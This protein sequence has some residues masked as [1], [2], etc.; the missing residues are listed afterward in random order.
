MPQQQDADT[1]SLSAV[2]RF[3]EP[4]TPPP[5]EPLA[6]TSQV[7]RS[8]RDEP[9]N[10]FERTPQQLCPPDTHAHSHAGEKVTPFSATPVVEQ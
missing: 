9:E 5:K 3:P 10:Q 8:R 7:N 2:Y 1:L 6:F 4:A